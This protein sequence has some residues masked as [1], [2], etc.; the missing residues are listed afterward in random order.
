LRRIIISGAALAVLVGA[1][2]AIAASNDFN[3]YTATETFSPSAAG[4]PKHPSGLSIHELWNAKGLNGS[5]TAPL[6]RIVAKMYGIKTDAKDFPTCTAKKIN[7]A[8]NA[9]GW[10][11]VCPKGSLIASGPVNSLFVPF[12]NGKAANPPQCN[13]WLSIYNGGVQKG[14]PVQVFFF[15]E[16]PDAPGPQYSCL[17]GAVHTGAAAAYNG[18]VTN[19]SSANHNIWSINIPLPANVSTSAG[20]IHGVYA[21]LVKL[22]VTYKKLSR[23]VNGH[24]VAYGASIGCKAGK[25]PYS[26]TFY[27]QN[28]QGSS[29]HTQTTTISHIAA[30]S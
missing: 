23:T 4:S 28:Y 19:P 22:N 14:A 15:S 24:K 8:G 20:G 10:N 21:S 12:N 26:F 18:Y 5:N 25:R 1:G 3:S 9:K 27:A 7:A 13:P 2:V 30:C 16:F 6:T 11:K 17:S 29:P